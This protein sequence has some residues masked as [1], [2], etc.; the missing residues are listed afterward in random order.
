MLEYSIK[1]LWG[2]TFSEL[3]LYIRHRNLKLI[4][5]HGSIDWGLEQEL[6]RTLKLRDCAIVVIINPS[7]GAIERDADR[8]VSDCKFSQR[9]AITGS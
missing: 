7:I 2:W 5:L 6:L 8:G 1:D 3:D 9:R 4:K